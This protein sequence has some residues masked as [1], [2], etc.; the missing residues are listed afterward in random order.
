[1]GFF[2][3]LGPS[4][5]GQPDLDVSPF[6]P[7]HRKTTNYESLIKNFPMR[8][9]VLFFLTFGLGT[10]YFFPDKGGRCE[11]WISASFAEFCQATTKGGAKQK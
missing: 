2:S 11:G 10:G 8:I 4:L 6:S 5:K 7:A 3:R 1:M 9:P